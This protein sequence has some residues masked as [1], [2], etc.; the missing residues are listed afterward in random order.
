MINKTHI[1]IYIFFT[2]TTWYMY[3]VLCKIHYT[4]IQRIVT[5]ILTTWPTCHLHSSKTFNQNSR[6]IVCNMKQIINHSLQLSETTLFNHQLAHERY[7]RVKTVKLVM[8]KSTCCQLANIVWKIVFISKYY[9]WS[10]YHS[11]IQ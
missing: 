3:S 9:T 2:F 5:S 7:R 11:C 8:K 10:W 6:F 1:Y 4:H